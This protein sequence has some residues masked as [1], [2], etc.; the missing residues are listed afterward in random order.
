MLNIIL[1]KKLPYEIRLTIYVSLLSYKR[2]KKKFNIVLNDLSNINK[3]HFLKEDLIHYTGTRFIEKVFDRISIENLL[4][5]NSLKILNNRFQSNT[6]F[7]LF[8]DDNEFYIKNGNLTILYNKDNKVQKLPFNYQD[9]VSFDNDEIQNNTIILQNDIKT[10]NIKFD[11]NNYLL[12]VIQISILDDYILMQSSDS[13]KRYFKRTSIW[14]FNRYQKNL[15]SELDYPRYN[16]LFK[17]IHIKRT[18]D[19]IEIK[20]FKKNLLKYDNG[21]YYK[22]LWKFAP[23]EIV[24]ELFNLNS[25]LINI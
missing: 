19:N 13:Y 8:Y 20:S 6:R 1:F 23:Q 4:F 3:I 12:Q 22:T 5:V 16:Y 21:N 18:V 2:K 15:S 14:D 11:Y 24:T 25:N 17:Q 10:I 7:V 9:I